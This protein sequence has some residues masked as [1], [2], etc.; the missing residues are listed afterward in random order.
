MSRYFALPVL[1]LCIAGLTLS[2]CASSSGL[3][4][5]SGDFPPTFE[6]RIS[7]IPFTDESGRAHE[8]PLLGGFNVPRPQL[9]DIDADGDFDLF[10]QEFTGEVMF[11]ENT[12]EPGAP[13]FE[14]RSDQFAG[15]D[16]GEWFR[17][18]DL[19]G[20]G[21][22]DIL[23]EERFSYVRYF[24]NE[25]SAQE[26]RFVAAVDTL[27]D[28]TGTPIFADRQNIPFLADIDCDN[29]LDLFIGRVDGTITRY[30]SVGM[31]DNNVPQFRF[32]TDRFEDIEIVGENVSVHG[33]NTMSFGD[34]DNDGDN[35]LL[36]GD[37]FEAGLLLIRNQGSCGSP[38]LRGEPQNWPL[39]NPIET[40]GYNAPVM[41][42]FDADGDLDVFMGVLG[43]AFNANSTTIDNFYYFE[44]VAEGQ[45]EK[46]AERFIYAVDLGSETIVKA[47]DL[48]ADGDLD[49]L[50]GNK[51]QPD[52]N[53]ISRVY[54]YENTGSPTSPAFVMRGPVE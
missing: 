1:G 36:W 15:L 7:E 5:D 25:G 29:L 42:D 37:F 33:A 22:M 26:A 12:G 44:Q 53:K 11:F 27:R 3:T 23:A 34:I 28:A 10:V 39:N 18:L 52:N 48:D 49:L 35:D 8:L 16:V 40:S 19:D 20:D 50:V 51:I 6:R 46:R 47:A 17:L 38:S 24:R 32:V 13:S 54:H 41:V 4:G 21:D 9:A 43:G 2:G 45:F 31:D 14:W 30:E